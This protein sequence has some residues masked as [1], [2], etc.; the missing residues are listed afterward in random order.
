VVVQQVDA[1]DDLRVPEHEAEPPAGHPVRLRHREH[2]DADLLRAGRGEEALRLAAVEDEV[3]IGE[4][5]HDR[6]IGLLRVRDRG[7]ERPIA[8]DDG[9][10]VRGVVQVDGCDLVS[11]RAR[12]V[13]LPV[14]TGVERYGL[15][16]SPGERW[17]GGVVR[18]PRIRQHNGR[19]ALGQHQR[20][21]DDRRLRSRDDREL[22]VRI[23]LDAIDGPVA[24]RDRL[25]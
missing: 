5:V 2:L 11:R 6:G 17:P 20:K 24:L 4:V 25:P 15:E 16:P 8:C 18:I 1:L 22:R 10:R 3:A 7:L 21:L 14:R 13:G 12:E 23:K 19:A 9:A